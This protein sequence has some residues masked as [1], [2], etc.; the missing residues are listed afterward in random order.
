MKV[1]IDFGT[2]TSEI[3]I[4]DSEGKVT[5]VPNHLGE[6]ITPSVVHF[7]KSGKAVVGR[8]ALEMA[9][10]EPEN[11]FLEV[12]RLFGQ[13]V[14]LESH[15]RVYEPVEIA[16]QIISYLVRCA[17]EYTGEII[18]SAVV[19]VPAYFTDAQRKDVMAA[20]NMAGVEVSRI[21]NEPTAASLDYGIKHMRDCNY[22]LVYD[23]GGGTLDVTVLEL[24]EGVVDVKSSCGNN[25]LGGKDFD[26][27][28]I[29]YIV[30]G[31][32]KQ[33]NVDV[34]EDKRAMMRIKIAAE[35]CKIA[36]SAQD[37][38]EI[39]LPFLFEGKNGEPGGFAEKITR[40]MFDGMIR[41]MIH[42]TKAQIDTA[43]ADADLDANDIDLTLMVGGSTRIP[44]VKNFLEKQFGFTPAQATDPDLAVVAGAAIQA[45][46]L[47][48]IL[49]ENAVILTD[50]CSYSLSTSALRYKEDCDCCRELY[51]DILI[52]RNSTLPASASSMYR[53][54]Y[55]DQ[56]MVH[57]TAYQGESEE[58]NENYLLNKFVLSGI[59]KGR[60]GTQK[61]NIEFEYDLN[62]I[63]VVNAQ[64]VSTGK[65]VT[66]T[67]DTAGLGKG[68]DLSA[69][70]DHPKAKDYRRFINKA[71]RLAKI[72]GEDAQDL[73][74]AADELKKALVLGW[75]DEVL[76]GLFRDLK[77]EIHVM[78]DVE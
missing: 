24:F 75:E 70:K 54:A 39:E 8:E 20:G 65:I 68:L 45:A 61:I 15:G 22:M 5:V 11:T 26:Q 50:I 9:I 48:G 77:N 47:D 2:S 4:C 3:A 12:K 43:L 37:A 10:L 40:N 59:P 55:D 33:S 63:L 25:T 30:R 52:P 18:N 71:D 56:H 32:K 46:V 66:A 31:I 58:P 34:T 60:A 53:T 17:Q 23:L 7:D 76:R 35:E 42:S 13:D 78:E 41:D 38:Y 67:I 49:G 44:L 6:I 51:C 29:D 21:I 62:G 69:W 57:I 14:K 64:I 74:S 73:T 28:I 1:G 36:L 72:H 19:T 27:A 16:A